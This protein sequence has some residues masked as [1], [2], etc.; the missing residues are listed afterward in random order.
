M[1]RKQTKLESVWSDAKNE[2]AP[3]NWL[4]AISP[5]FVKLAINTWEHPVRIL[6][7]GEL[8]Q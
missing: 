6:Y 1:Q 8:W 5:A 3:L 7:M 2:F 4:R